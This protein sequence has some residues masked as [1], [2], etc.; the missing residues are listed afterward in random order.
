VVNRNG[1]YSQAQRGEVVAERVA[2]V[3]RVDAFALERGV[4][5]RA[6]PGSPRPEIGRHERDG[7]QEVE[8][9]H[10]R[11]DVR[12]QVA[13]GARAVRAAVIEPGRRATLACLR[14]QSTAVLPVCPP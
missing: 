4:A 10:A 5:Q 7:L 6:V 11:E 13:P 3:A 14:I 12:S 8:S 9:A 1:A 2:P